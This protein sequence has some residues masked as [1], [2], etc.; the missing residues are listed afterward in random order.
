MFSPKPGHRKRP[1]APFL[2]QLT[3][4]SLGGLGIECYMSSQC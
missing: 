2:N 1:C 3:W 4:N